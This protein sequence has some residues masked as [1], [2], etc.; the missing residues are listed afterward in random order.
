MSKPHTPLTGKVVCDFS[1]IVQDSYAREWHRLYCRTPLALK[2]ASIITCRYNRLFPFS[3]PS[4]R[5]VILSFH[6]S[7]CASKCEKMEPSLRLVWGNGHALDEA[8]KA[9]NIYERERLRENAV[10]LRTKASHEN[11]RITLPVRLEVKHKS[12]HDVR[13][14]AKAGRSCFHPPCFNLFRPNPPISISA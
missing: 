6:T 7:W 1:E 3:A 11:S 10:A 2:R 12:C 4:Y 14:P 5:N 13:S 9:T 8:T